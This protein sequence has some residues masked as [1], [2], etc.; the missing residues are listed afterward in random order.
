METTE[1]KE[2]D[3]E[4]EKLI[5]QTV[6][7]L[8]FEIVSAIEDNHPDDLDLKEYVTC[9]TLAMAYVIEGIA[10][11]LTHIKGDTVTF[12]D[13]MFNIAFA[14]KKSKKYRKEMIENASKQ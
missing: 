14:E 3:L 2:A 7:D 8:E 5:H 10:N 11:T 1:N 9:T 13:V 12:S 6:I 4:K